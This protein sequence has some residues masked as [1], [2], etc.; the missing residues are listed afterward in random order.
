MSNDGYVACICEGSAEKAI[1]ELLL[2]EDKLQFDRGKMIENEVIQCRDGKSFEVKYLR[3]YFELKIT[4][5]RI[6][7]SR[8]ENFKLSKAYAEKIKVVNVI[9]APEIEM[10][11][12]FNEDKYDDFK[13]SRLKPSLF[14]KTILKYKNVKSYIFIKEY[15]KDPDVLISCLKKYKSKSAVKSGECTLFDLLKPEF[16]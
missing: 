11:V 14:C 7:D 4:V 6:L 3:K 16:Q 13:K 9:T 12:I 15:F 1:I 2:E 10:L 8:R 5:Y